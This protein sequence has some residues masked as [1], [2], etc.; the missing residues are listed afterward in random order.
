MAGAD[1]HR[2]NG[3]GEAPQAEKESLHRRVVK[4]LVA[5][6]PR[7]LKLRLDDL[8]ARLAAAN[9][10]HEDLSQRHG[11]LRSWADEKVAMLDER[12]QRLERRID[13]AEALGQRLDAVEEAL[14][15]QQAD[16][17]ETA[18]AGAALAHRIDTVER[19]LA[20]VGAEVARLRDDVLPAVAERGDVLLDRLHQEIEEVASLTE[21]L[22]AREPLPTPPASDPGLA[23]VLDDVHAT[24]VEALRGD[25]EEITHRLGADLERLRDHGPVL[26]LGCGRGELLMLLREAGVEARGVDGDAAL[27]Q[28]ARRRGLDVTEADVLEHLGTVPEGSCGAITAY[29]LL[30]HL[31]PADLARLLAEVRKALR[32]GGILLAES[33][34]PHS[35]RVGASLF[36]LDPTHQRPLMPE[37]LELFLTAAGLEVMESGRRHPFPVEQRFAVDGDNDPDEERLASLERRLDGL[38]NAERDFFIVARKP[39]DAAS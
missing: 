28:G 2:M 15:R 20:Q 11:A 36:W 8:E 25:S 13:A 26:D 22:L 16:A 10:A 14:R 4:A 17:E 23:R 21:R 29:H 12:G 9:Q 33:P 19:A 7:R 6:N 24:L 1:G 35:L 18:E 32:P 27:V 5:M 30:E 34:N 39:T 3:P 31:A 38:L 37:T